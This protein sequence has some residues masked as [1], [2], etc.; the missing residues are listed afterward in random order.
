MS[1]RIRWL[2][3]LINPHTLTSLE[4]RVKFLAAKRPLKMATEHIIQFSDRVGYK[5]MSYQR[6]WLITGFC[7]GYEIKDPGHPDMTWYDA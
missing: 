5:D 7:Y 2:D 4:G 6:T 3:G 1:C